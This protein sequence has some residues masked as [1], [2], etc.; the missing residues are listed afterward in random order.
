MNNDSWVAR[1]TSVPVASI[2]A[3]MAGSSKMSRAAIHAR[4]TS[5]T[6]APVS[7]VIRWSK[8]IPERLTIWLT[9]QVRVISAR[10]GCS[11]IA[12]G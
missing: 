12:S 7:S 3:H 2:V 4:V 10:S 1:V 9:R 5:A 11:R 8:V 6:V